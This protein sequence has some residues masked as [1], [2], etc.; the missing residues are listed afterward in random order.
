MQAATLMAQPFDVKRL[1][2]QGDAFPVAEQVWL[3]PAPA[4]GYGAFSVS[5]NGVLA[6]RTLGQATTELVWFDRQGKRLETVGEP[7]NYSL[8]A[9]STDEK[10]LAVARIDPQIGTKDL[11]L[12]D[13]PRRTLSRFTFDPAEET[14]PTWSPDGN[15]IAFSSRGNGNLDI[16]QKAATGTGKADRCWNPATPNLFRIGLR[17]AGSSSM[18]RGA[19]YG[20]CP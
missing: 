2:S 12:F 10:R 5:G 9:L 15:R 4:Q 6:Y 18:I 20:R 13:L 14:N 17:T 19:S 11:W 16:Y 7:A 1:E 3:P 8:P